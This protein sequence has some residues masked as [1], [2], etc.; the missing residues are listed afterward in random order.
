MHERIIRR[1]DDSLVVPDE[2]EEIRLFLDHLL[3]PGLVDHVFD[4]LDGRVFVVA[5]KVKDHAE[6][7]HFAAFSRFEFGVAV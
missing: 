2:K 6:R 5:R 4:R 7:G 1:S 3:E